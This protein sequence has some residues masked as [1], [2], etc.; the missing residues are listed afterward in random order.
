MDLAGVFLFC[1]S[2]KR[3]APQT[4]RKKRHS[5]PFNLRA[6][7]NVYRKNKPP[8]AAQILSHTEQASESALDTAIHSSHQAADAMPSYVK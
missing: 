4:Q 3:P 8:K 2:L 5:K 6:F 1:H 7:I